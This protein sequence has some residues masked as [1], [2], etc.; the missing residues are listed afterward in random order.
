MAGLELKGEEGCGATAAV[1]AR[2]EEKE[3]S[4]PLLY[5]CW[6]KA[7]AEVCCVMIEPSEPLEYP[8][9][10]AE[11]GFCSHSE[12][13]RGGLQ[14]ELITLLKEGV[15]KAELTIKEDLG[16]SALSLTT[17]GSGGWLSEPGLAWSGSTLDT[18][19]ALELA[20]NGEAQLS[21]FLPLS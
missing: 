17:K 16:G 21:S 11:D 2:E 18:D 12:P 20:A 9:A 15:G 6:E 1:G 4:E 8:A 14:G 5:C 7:A 19:C 3:L 10:A 13:K